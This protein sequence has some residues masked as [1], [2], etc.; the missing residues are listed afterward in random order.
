MAMAGCDAGNTSSSADAGDNPKAAAENAADARVSEAAEQA[1]SEGL[2]GSSAAPPGHSPLDAGTQ[3]QVDA[4]GA[5][6][7]DGGVSPPMGSDAGSRHTPAASRGCQLQPNGAVDREAQLRNLPGELRGSFPDAYDGVTPQPLIVA[8]HAT[9]STVITQLTEDE[10]LRRRYVVLAPSAIAFGVSR[11]DDLPNTEEL[12][13]LLE[14]VNDTFCIDET[15]IFGVGNGSGGR[16]LMQW[17]S[18]R[19]GMQRN[20]EPREPRFF[21]TALVSSFTSS[22]DW[23]PRPTLFIHGIDA[24]DGSDPDGTQGLALLR[25]QNECTAAATAITGIGCEDEAIHPGC[26]DF[27]ECSADLRWCQHD[28]P[29]QAQAGDPWPCF[30]SSAIRQFFDGLQ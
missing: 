29:S 12:S 25:E 10:P 4:V 15:R 5:R 26:V 1:P 30:A 16:F 6:S 18:A 24:A 22:W 11:F 7:Q 3:A 20:T 8:L 19:D 14:Q 21:A 28:D 27:A 17:V 9:S 2:D 13:E 23:L